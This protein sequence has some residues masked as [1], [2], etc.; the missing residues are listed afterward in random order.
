MAPLLNPHN[1]TRLP[2][3]L[4][5]RHALNV[6]DGP[7]QLNDAHVGHAALAVDGQLCDTLDP[8]LDRVGD[9]RDD[10]H[11]LTQV[12]TTALALNHVL[13]SGSGSARWRS[14]RS[15]HGGECPAAWPGAGRL[16]EGR[17]DIPAWMLARST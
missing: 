16:H 1:V 13:R 11:R 6:S 10:L 14:W 3:S 2:Q 4:D 7:A 15:M 17:M 5:K 12:V 9:V 8:V